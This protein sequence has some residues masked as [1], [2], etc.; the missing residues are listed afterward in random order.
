VKL[1]VIIRQ[2]DGADVVSP[3]STVRRAP[4]IY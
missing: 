4:S 3:D 2:H 1:I